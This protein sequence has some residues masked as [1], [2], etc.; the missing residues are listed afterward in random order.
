MAVEVYIY[1][2]NRSNC[3]FPTIY[4]SY[5]ELP[6]NINTISGPVKA[7][8]L[9]VTVEAEAGG[10]HEFLEVVVHQSKSQV[11]LQE[12]CSFLLGFF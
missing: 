10:V 3:L 6:Y 1:A 8:L 9:T 4:A 12:D 5:S 11:V 2:L 7:D